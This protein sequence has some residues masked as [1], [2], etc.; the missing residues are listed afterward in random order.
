[1]IVAVAILGIADP[2]NDALPTDDKIGS[3]RR[4]SPAAGV[5]EEGEHIATVKLTD[6]LDTGGSMCAEKALE[7]ARDEEFHV[8]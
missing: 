3:N 1:V 8:E 6:D 7:E 5:L 2:L 4:L